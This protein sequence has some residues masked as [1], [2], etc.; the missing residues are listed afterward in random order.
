MRSC[1]R[2]R[3]SRLVVPPA[4]HRTAHPVRRTAV[5]TRGGAG[6]GSIRTVGVRAPTQQG[7][8]QGP[9]EPSAPRRPRAGRPA[10]R[11][12]RSPSWRRCARRSASIGRFDGGRR[13]RGDP[14]GVRQ[15]ARP[16]ERTRR[17]ARDDGGRSED[18]LR[19][20]P[21]DRGV[22]DRRRAARGRDGARPR[23]RPRSPRTTTCR[24]GVRPT[25]PRSSSLWCRLQSASPLSTV[26]GP[27]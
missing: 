19:T 22:A 9:A 23:C 10:R 14:G 21:V 7:Q 13:R 8:G 4:G 11:L 5:R 25:R 6:R 24:S 1:T 18:C 27:S 3:R 16:P 2:P 12:R 17:C 26:S 15:R 20:T